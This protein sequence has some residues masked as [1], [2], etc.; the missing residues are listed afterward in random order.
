MHLAQVETPR[1]GK[2]WVWKN[3]KNHIVAVAGP[4][5]ARFLG[6]VVRTLS[7]LGAPFRR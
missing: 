2:V 3:E 1:G 4:G 5:E 7:S 6:E